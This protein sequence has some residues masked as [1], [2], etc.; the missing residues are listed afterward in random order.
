[1]MGG[2]RT[3]GSLA[4]WAAC[5]ALYGCDAELTGSSAIRVFGRTGVGPGEFSYPRAVARTD[6]GRLFIVDKSGR[7][8]VLDDAGEPVISW[9]LPESDAGKPTGLGLGPDGR[10]YVADT[11]YSRVLVYEPDGVLVM[12][13]GTRGT[14]PGEFLLPT[15]VAVDHESF[16]YVGEYSGNDRIS[17]FAADGTFIMTFDGSE[18]GGTALA[19]PQSLTWGPDGNLWVADACNHR[20]CWFA[21]DGELL[22]TFG[23]SGDEP[24][25]MR[26]PYGLDWLSDGTL[27]VAEYGNNRIQR[28]DREGR[29]LGIWGRAGRR[30]GELAYPWAVAVGEED[31]I[32]VID[33]GNN[34]VQVV[35]AAVVRAASG[36]TT[37]SAYTKVEP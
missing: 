14:A 23:R 33:S 27:I 30:A 10:L 22:G 1:M 8:Q 31:D 24:G 19:R 9:E 36:T 17:K 6:E 4:I 35:P 13:F 18:S 21:R 28:F 15:D 3:T 26:F 29:S 37:A 25:A 32:F 5:A 16:I 2:R 11:H 34:R 20:I 7:I 12:S